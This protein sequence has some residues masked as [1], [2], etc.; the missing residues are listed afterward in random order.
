MVVEPQAGVAGAAVTLV[1][2]EEQLDE[3]AALA[4]R[5]VVRSWHAGAEGGAISLPGT[6]YPLGRSL[7]DYRLTVSPGLELGF[8]AASVRFAVSVLE[9][10]QPLPSPMPPAGYSVL[11]TFGSPLLT[12]LQPR[13]TLVEDCNGYLYGLTSA[14][15]GYETVF[16]MR[17]DGGDQQTLHTFAVDGSQ[18]TQPYGGLIRATL[19]LG[20]AEISDYRT[21]LFGTMMGGGR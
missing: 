21:A 17:K 5:L 3:E 9:D 2:S 19:D 1:V 20:G 7:I 13:G 16:R 12:G 4:E 8:G 15:A 10:C 11:A 6:V 18:G 14:G